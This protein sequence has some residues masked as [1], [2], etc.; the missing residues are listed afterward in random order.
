MHRSRSRERALRAFHPGILKPPPA[1]SVYIADPPDPARD[2]FAPD[3][4]EMRARRY[5]RTDG[6]PQ[7]YFRLLD[8]NEA[9][10]S[11]RCASERPEYH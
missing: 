2:L 8:K 10:E 4:R 11:A 3:K 6:I 7:T 1:T 9:R 5:R